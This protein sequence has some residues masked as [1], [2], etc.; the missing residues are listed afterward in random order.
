MKLSSII[1]ITALI[2][3][4]IFSALLESAFTLPL[5]SLISVLPLFTLLDVKSLAELLR[6]GLPFLIPYNLTKCSFLITT[7]R[8]IAL[9][10]PISILL[11]AL[12][13]TAV[14]SIS[15]FSQLFAL[16]FYPRSC[17]VSLRGVLILSLLYAFSEYFPSHFG[18]LSFP[19]LGVWAAADGAPAILLSASL[20]GCRFTSLLI[21]AANGLIYL[22]LVRLAEAKLK[23]ALASLLGVTLLV[24]SALLGG[25]QQ[26]Y[27][28]NSISVSSDSI[29]VMAAQLDCEGEEKSNM[30]ADEAAQKY[31]Q[32]IRTNL[33]DKISL[34]FLPE[35]AVH[36][37][38]SPDSSAFSSLL[39]LTEREN[40]T[41]FSG[42]FFEENTDKF[43]S[44]V[45]LI[46]DKGECVYKKHFLVPFGE[47]T[48]FHSDLKAADKTCYPYVRN[49]VALASCICIESIF[50]DSLRECVLNGANLIY[51]P[52][53]DSWFGDSFARHAHYLHSK[54]RAIECSRF[55]IRASNCGISAIIS[56]TGEAVAEL[57]CKSSGAIV[58]DVSLLSHISLYT[59]V[60]DLLMLLPT[61]I[62]FHSLLIK[63][64]P[65]K[66]RTKGLCQPNRKR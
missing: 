5:L 61:L 40:I 3:Y 38:F 32:L 39:G 25:S 43:N 63:R 65:K 50:S 14:A 66:P 48:P 19:W 47:Y 1:R 23:S 28:L 42:C 52:T 16:A 8:L 10:M 11:A 21:L 45:S 60:G 55:V 44:I 29:T 26:A 57:S 22:S 13:V 34:V 64:K 4:G 58:G 20:F 12:A 27:Y 41:I 9:P 24:S 53:N 6:R 33:N 36:T 7:Y 35:T 2:F 54:M 31:S 15:L 46:G 56:P 51:I 18:T 30:S 62:I 49:S 59:R 37:S 17:S